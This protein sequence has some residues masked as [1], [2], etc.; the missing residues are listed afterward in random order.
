MWVIASLATQQNWKDEKTFHNLGVLFCPEVKFDWFVHPRWSAKQ[1][2]GGEILLV[3]EFVWRKSLEFY[4]F[5]VKFIYLLVK[6][7]KFS[8]PKN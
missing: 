7:Y 1:L 5:S 8:Q 3:Y 6:I 2:F 4:F